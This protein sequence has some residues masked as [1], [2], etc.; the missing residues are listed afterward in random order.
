MDNILE[1]YRYAIE[2]YAAYMQKQTVELLRDFDLTQSE[3]DEYYS[4][5][6]TD[7]IKSLGNN[8]AY[9]QLFVDLVHCEILEKNLYSLTHIAKGINLDSPGYVIQSWL[10]DRNTLELLRCWELEYNKDLF[11]DQAALLLIEKTREPSFTIT[12]KIWCEKT[13]AKGII[14]KQG[15]NGGTY[16]YQE[17]AV[18][19]LTWASPVHRYKLSKMIISKSLAL[20]AVY[21]KDIKN[22]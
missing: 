11:D 19:F 18:D 13:K 21:E 3:I 15:K 1:K 4:R 20:E 14:S 8:E 5:Y 17:I 7:M 6:K 12:A 9:A 2:E 10:R 16:A 22:E